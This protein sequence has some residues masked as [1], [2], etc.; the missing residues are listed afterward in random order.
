MKLSVFYVFY[1]HYYEAHK[2]INDHFL[3]LGYGANP[4]VCSW[5]PECQR[6]RRGL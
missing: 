4:N 2:D 5:R 3:L 6:R 1:G